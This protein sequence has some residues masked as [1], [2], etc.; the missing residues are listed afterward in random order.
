MG[1]IELRQLTYF[2]EVANRE[3]VTEA[4]HSLHVAQSAVSR[5]I[6]NLENELGIEL[7]VRTGRRVKLTPIGKIF[8]KYAKQSLQALEQG[9]EEIEDFLNPEKGVIR[10]GF[11]SSLASY[12]LPSVISAFREKYPQIGFQLKQSSVQ[13]LIELL[14]NGEID[15]VFLGPVPTT[16]KGVKSKI[17]FAENIVG[18]L[19]SKHRLAERSYIRLNELQNDPFILFPSGY[20]L[21]QLVIDA[22]AQSGFV[23]EVPF[24]GEDIDAIKG[25]VSAGLGVTLLPEVTLV[26]SLP[27]TTVKIPI[28]EPSVTRTVGAIIPEHR[29]LAPSEQLFY[30]FLTDFFDV[31][32]KFSG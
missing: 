29:K 25:L 6:S 12:T 3:H 16:M 28:V 4:A 10:V 11:T 15:L 32:N 13:H 20:V 14:L 23:P 9:R 17:F 7:F 8:L 27:R 24:E 19:P 22:C 2:I 18:L 30:D 26:D 1:T 31:L 5:Q 21:R